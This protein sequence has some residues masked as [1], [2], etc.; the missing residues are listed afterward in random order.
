MRRLHLLLVL[1]S[2]GACDISPHEEPDAGDAGDA[3][4]SEC[5][6][7]NDC[8]ACQ[9]CAAQKACAKL[10]T[11]CQQSP[12]CVGLDQCM[13]LCGSDVS[14][15]QQ[16]GASNP[17]GAPTYAA[18]VDCLACDQCPGDCAGYYECGS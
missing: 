14:C 13:K 7:K 6:K 5:D 12:D 3:A 9:T 15:R 16:C 18:L 8:Q 17:G 2:L 11:A 1:A 10:V 4:V